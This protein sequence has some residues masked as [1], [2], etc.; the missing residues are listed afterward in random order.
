MVKTEENK[1]V[2]CP[3]CSGSG[4]GKVGLACSN[5]GGLGLGISEYG[6]FFYWGKKISGAL[7]ELDH[8]KKKLNLAVNLIAFL[9]GLSGLICL[10]YWVY[11]VSKFASDIKNFSFWL[12]RNNF[13]LFFWASV[14]ADMFIIYRISQ[15]EAKSARIKSIGYDDTNRIIKEPKSWRD[16]KKNKTK[17]NV[18][19]G[20]TG[21]AMEILE[22][23][24]LLASKLGHDEIKPIHLF[25]SC[26]ADK[27]VAAIFSRLNVDGKKLVEKLN[28]QLARIA[29]TGKSPALGNDAKEVMINSYLNA[30][31]SRLRNVTPKNFLMPC[32]KQ[33]KILYE[34]LY[35]LEIDN[36][37]IGNV[38]SWFNIN[39]KLLASY[40]L[41][42]KMA[43][44][45]PGTTMDRAYTAVATPTLNHFSYDLTVAA[46]WGKLEF[47]V[48]REKEMTK[49]WENFESGRN[50][51]L[52]VGQPGVGKDAVINGIAQL[53]VE[54]SV[55]AMFKD[56]RLVELD[57]ARLVSGATPAEAQARMLNAIDEIIRA[58]NIIL[59]IDNIENMIGITSG[60]EESLDLSEVLSGAIEKRNFYCLATVTNANFTKY[61]ETA[62]LGRSMA[63]VE[64]EEPVGNQAIIIIESKIAYLEGKYKVYFSYSAIE[65]VIVMSNKFIHDSYL[66]KKAIDILELV[67]VKVA[68]EKG[69]QSVVT[70]DDIAEVVSELTHIPVSKISEA[71]SKNLLQ[72]EELIH[73]RMINQETAVKMVAASLR[74][75][76]ANLREGKRPIANFL[77]L[78]PTGVGKTELAK[79][80]SEIYFGNE[81]F[82]IR[83][84][85]SEYQHPDSV[86]K[87][88]GDENGVV[89][90]LTEA[91][92]KAPFSL[93]LLDEFEKAHPNILN[94]FLQ[95]FDDGRL[96]DGQGR[97]VDFTNSIII[98]TSNVGAVYIQEEIFKGTSIDIIKTTLINEQL[99]KAMRPELINRFDGVI[100]FEPL[101]ME[102]VVA[103][104]K[105]MIN[106]VGKI[107]EAKGIG[108][109]AEE[110]G[111]RKLAKDGYDPK[112]GARPLRRLIQERIEDI[113]ANKIL[114]DELKR[115][116][117]VIITADA[118][119]EIE[120]ARQL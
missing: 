50:G 49:I 113:I 116:D 93:I 106:G 59:Y 34:I 32:L 69:K 6:A 68:K 64:I 25:C 89:G 26:L 29:K 118:L 120:K 12:E 30:R 2:I 58:G 79:T 46:K 115:R 61:I 27:Q 36:D 92:R 78:G 9:V 99:N 51:I 114:A 102:N 35:D 105:L 60:A 85:M 40:R 21:A 67:A 71:E 45:K 117:T 3:V 44:F 72:L 109:R 77:F 65:Q 14:I 90:Y 42:R 66:P 104:T 95:V 101:S 91:V 112:F 11:E 73:T 37:K 54:E 22:K 96:T 75:A 41:Y 48:A 55:P 98:A 5:C 63:K 52:L 31:A 74:R 56:K 119:I 70:K 10:G 87:M 97:T 24:Y 88:I 76:R 1:F 108:L 84:D 17:I 111:I 39:D 20:F 110:D 13:I 4:S 7:I 80:V 103:V 47:C 94:L 100:V 38:I 83:L 18:A 57:V 43:R 81:K 19:T 33:D 86:N 62:P 8:I 107:L 53:M 23:S 82:M 16:F 15:E 28:N